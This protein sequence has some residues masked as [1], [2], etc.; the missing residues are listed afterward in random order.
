MVA[1]KVL[2]PEIAARPELIERFK[3]E[4]RLARKITHK[5]VCRIHE[6]LRFG[7][8]VAISMEY[9]EGESLRAVLRRFG[10]VPLGRGQEW[11]KQICSGLAEAHAQG[12]VHRDLT[13]IAPTCRAGRGIQ[14]RS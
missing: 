3:A 11:V 6:L 14:R 7:D 4:L 2:L 12:V 8:T 5:N 10:D 1:L 13:R 9:V